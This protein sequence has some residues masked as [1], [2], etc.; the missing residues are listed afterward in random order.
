MYTMEAGA[1]LIPDGEAI[2]E[3]GVIQEASNLHLLNRLNNKVDGDREV[4]EAQVAGGRVVEETQE[5]DGDNRVEETQEA[6]GASKAVGKVKQA[7][8]SKAAAGASKE[9]G[10]MMEDSLSK[11]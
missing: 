7:G 10:D 8:V 4:E 5:E 9:D 3:D 6:A 11:L 1:T 2:M